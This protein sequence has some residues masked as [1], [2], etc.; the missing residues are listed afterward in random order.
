VDVQLPVADVPTR[1][2]F[3]QIGDPQVFSGGGS[4]AAI[5]AAGA[6]A[7]ALLVTRLSARRRSNADRREAL[8]AAISRI[9]QLQ[10]RLY[11]AADADIACLDRLLIAQ[12]GARSGGSRADY[13]AA[14]TDAATS[15]IELAETSLVLL[16]EIA[17]QSESATRFTVSD[18]GAAA[19]LAEGAARAALLTAEV[20]LALLREMPDSDA[21]RVRVLEQRGSQAYRRSRQLADE[22]ESATRS[23]IHGGAGTAIG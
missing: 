19:V 13:L 6:A 14:L 18:L 2:F 7:L 22:I 15:P 20:N 21:A 9:E 11:A 4:V 17:A 3:E 1:R 5:G 12:R 10:Q 23:A 8:T 16:G